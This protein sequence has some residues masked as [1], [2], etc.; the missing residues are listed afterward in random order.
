MILVARQAGCDQPLADLGTG[1]ALEETAFSLPEQAL[2]DPVRTAAGWAVL[3]V[4]EKKPFDVNGVPEVYAS[5][6]RHLPTT[7]PENHGYL[8]FLYPKVD[9]WDGK[10]L[11]FTNNEKANEFIK[12]RFRK[13]WELK[14]VTV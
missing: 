13:G 7:R 8:T 2:S 14:D 6:F 11:R 10:N 9:L 1:G 3:R 4:L 12:P 5:L